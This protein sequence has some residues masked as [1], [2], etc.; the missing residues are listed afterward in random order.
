LEK[1]FLHSLGHGV[2]VNVHE[3][4][5]ISPKSQDILKENMAITIEPGLYIA[6]KFGVRIEDMIVFKKERVINLTNSQKELIII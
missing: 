3:T 2:G 5:T 4:P 6:K 1:Y